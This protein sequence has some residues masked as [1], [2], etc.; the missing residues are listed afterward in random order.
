MTISRP[1]P[2]PARV[3]LTPRAPSS[4]TWR[5]AQPVAEEIDLELARVQRPGHLSRSVPLAAFRVWHVH[6]ARPCQVASASGAC[7]GIDRVVHVDLAVEIPLADAQ[8]PRG[9]GA[10]AAGRGQR[11]LDSGCARTRATCT[12]AAAPPG[13]RAGRRATA[14]RA[15][16]L[17]AKRNSSSSVA[18]ETAT[19]SIAPIRM[20]ASAVSSAPPPPSAI[21]PAAGRQTRIAR[22]TSGPSAASTSLPSSRTRSGSN[23]ARHV[24]RRSAADRLRVESHPLDR[25]DEDAAGLPDRQRRGE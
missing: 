4:D 6:A 22:R 21:T 3:R 2:S 24:Q 7:W 25:R 9:A 15:F 13:A 10:A 8:H 5:H 14:G 23:P 20:A 16:H 17:A 11:A 18:R 19:S 1:E 12:W